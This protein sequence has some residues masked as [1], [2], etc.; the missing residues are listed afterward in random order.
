M[1]RRPRCR[2]RGL[3][4]VNIERMVSMID[5]NGW[6]S[7]KPL[8]HGRIESVGT[9]EGLMKRSPEGS[10]PCGC[11]RDRGRDDGGPRVGQT[12]DPMCSVN[13]LG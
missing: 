4:S 11:H 6:F 3:P 12:S 5:V 9:N 8:S 2:G 13:K 10:S 7:A 1:R